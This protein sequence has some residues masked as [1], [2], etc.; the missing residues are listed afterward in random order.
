MSQ[1]LKVSV[2]PPGPGFEN[3]GLFESRRD[4]KSPHTPNVHWLDYLAA[5]YK[6]AGE[7]GILFGT[8]D[9]LAP[10][11]ADVL[12]YLIWP[13]SPYDVKVEKQKHPHL[14]TILLYIETSLGSRYVFNPENHTVFDAVISDKTYLVD[15]KR[16]FFLP[17]RAFYRDRIKIGLPFEERKVGC[18]IS[19]NRKMGRLR[20]GLFA[21][22]KGWKFS[23]RDWLDYAFL[24]GQLI[25]YRANVGKACA[26]YRKNAF[27]IYG[28]GWDLMPETR[29]I[30][31]GILREPNLNHIG[32]YRYY[33]A[34]ENHSSDSSA[35]SEKIWDALWGDA[36]PVHRGNIGLDKFIPRQ[37]F[38]NASEFKSPK[39]MLDW[40]YYSS[41]DTWTKYHE[42]GRNFIHSK[43]VEAFLPEAFADRFI[44]QIMSIAD[45]NQPD[46][47]EP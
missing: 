2:I 33:F 23:V 4:D 39:E 5:V 1:A 15:N 3:N 27:D 14:K 40:L 30:Y 18:L 43:A 16:Y 22:R 25:S 12:I 9:V 44:Q 8:S 38:I 36:V 32:N 6:R 45:N 37:C 24:Q 19:S 46:E 47:N 21:M 29:F 10:K 17:P 41:K 13:N 42:A 20:T 11:E 34:F 7:M 28:E 35:I 26:K 31:R